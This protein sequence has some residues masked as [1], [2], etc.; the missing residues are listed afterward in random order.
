MRAQ[1]F[2]I[3]KTVGFLY[4]SGV[5]HCFNGCK[6]ADIGK[7]RDRNTPSRASFSNILILAGLRPLLVLKNYPLCMV[8][9]LS[10]IDR[11]H[12]WSHPWSVE[13]QKI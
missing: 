13:G 10:H 8:N 12:P 9:G 4:R 2:E 1:W 6:M 3:V 5:F 11:I 7:I